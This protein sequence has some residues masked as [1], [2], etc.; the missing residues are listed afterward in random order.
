VTLINARFLPFLKETKA[1]VNVIKIKTEVK[2]LSTEL[3]KDK[4][5]ELKV[6]AK[7]FNSVKSYNV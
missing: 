6:K 7:L 3:G 5:G 2:L 1:R 4:E